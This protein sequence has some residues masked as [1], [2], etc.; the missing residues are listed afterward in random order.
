MAQTTKIAEKQPKNNLTFYSKSGLGSEDRPRSLAATAAGFLPRQVVTILLARISMEQDRRK[1]TSSRR[2]TPCRAIAS[3]HDV[4]SV[5]PHAVALALVCTLGIG[6]ADGAGFSAQAPARILYVGDSLA[7]NTADTVV[8]V[9]QGTDKR[10]ITSHSAFPGMAICDFLENDNAEMPSADRLQARIRKNRPDLVIMQ[11]WGNAFT[12]CMIDAPF[13]TTEYFHRYFL[14][15]DAAVRL[16][17]A[18]AAEIGIPRPRIMWVLQGPEPDLPE[19]TPVLNSIFGWIAAVHADRTSDAGRTLS[20]AA[21]PGRSS[22]DGA[23]DRWTQFSPC[24]Q[25][26]RG[27]PLCTRPDTDGGVAQLHRDDDSIH[28]CLG[29]HKYFFQCDAPSP[30]ITRYGNQI[31]EDA[32]AWL[33]LR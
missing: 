28:F 4:R 9:T 22:E 23:R 7:A 27:T 32:G 2:A 12:K 24:T 3:G 20:V 33:G 8:N 15:A 5:A 18:T 1:Q 14:D 21:D 30:A 17:E 13:N 25:G 19:R 26:E 31:A 16:I 29:R 6:T 10:A 11:F